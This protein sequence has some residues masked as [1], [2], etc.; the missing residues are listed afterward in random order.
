MSRRRDTCHSRARAVFLAGAH[1]SSPCEPGQLSPRGPGQIEP[2]EGTLDM[3][4]RNLVIAA[5]AA[6]VAGAL[7]A[8]IAFAAEA[9]ATAGGSGT[10]TTLSG[11]GSAFGGS[12]GGTLGNNGGSLQ[13]SLPGVPSTP[14]VP[15]PDGVID[16]FQS[17]A[18]EFASD[19]QAAI[20]S[21]ASQADAAA[22]KAQANGKDAFDDMQ[23]QAKDAL[24]K[25]EAQL[26]KAQNQL[27]DA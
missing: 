26:D 16:S 12:A 1:R 8:T 23:A 20:T 10:S 19:L 15:S 14:D 21:A 3:N 6:T 24:A 17:G 27:Q 2:P 7:S 13:V 11:G 4:A 22:D 25:G 9:H 5:G 18:Q